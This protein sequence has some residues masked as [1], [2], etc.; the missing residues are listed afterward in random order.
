MPRSPPSSGPLSTTHSQLSTSWHATITPRRSRQLQASLNHVFN[1]CF[2]LPAS[3]LS[4]SPALSLPIT[5]PHPIAVLQSG[6]PSSTPYH[7]FALDPDFPA[8]E[9]HFF[10]DQPPSQFSA[11][12]GLPFTSSFG[13]NYVRA[14]TISELRSCY[15]APSILLQV[16]PRTATPSTY[17]ASC[18][19]C[20]PF[21]LGAHF[22]NH[23]IDIHLFTFIDAATSLNE[24]ITRLLVNTV[25]SA[26]PVPSPLNWL[27]AYDQDADTKLMLQ[28]LTKSAPA[29]G[30][31][32]SNIV[33]RLATILYI[34]Y[35]HICCV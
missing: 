21:Q 4:P 6:H 10:P 23:L 3:A 30:P 27:A 7:F 32:Y 35:M 12:F 18:S 25:S 13:T 11:T 20:C 16:I 33:L 28:R 8:S 2:P 34:L 26:R 19:T 24:F 9:P 5:V 29:A 15:S 1:D 14:F 22:V 31:C 17:A